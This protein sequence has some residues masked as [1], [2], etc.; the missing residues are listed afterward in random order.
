MNTVKNYICIACP[1][2][3]R[4]ELEAEGSEIVRISGNNCPRGEIYAKEEFTSPK[5][6]VTA[7][8]PCD[9][10]T[11]RRVPVKSD[12]PV[13]K[14]Q[15]GALLAQIYQTKVKGP[16]KSGS[17]IIENFEGSGVN[18]VTTREVL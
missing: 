4:L 1:V 12:R 15:I 5:R 7:T 18:V 8:A 14:A 9:S 13:L 16:A 6:T 2:G 3:C 17:V 11:L 10:E